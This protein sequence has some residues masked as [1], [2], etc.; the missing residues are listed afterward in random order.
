MVSLIP[1]ICGYFLDILI[2]DPRQLPHPVRAIGLLISNT[3]KVLRKKDRFLK[4]KGL[5]L[6]IF[7]SFLSFIIPYI[8][9]KFLN[10]INVL[11]GVIISSLL[12]FQIL[13]TKSLY[14]ETIKVYKAL[15]CGNIQLAKKEL[16]YLVSRDCETM[17]EEDIIRSTIETISENIVDGITSP[18]FY[19][20]L[21]GAP[22]GMFYK[23]VN[24]LDSMVGYKNE[25]YMDFGYFSAKFDDVINF[26]PARLTSYLIVF[27]SFVLRLNYKD[28]YTI[29]K[30]DKANHSS[31]NSGYA[32][33]PVAG[34]LGI[35]LGGKVSY[36]GVIHNKPTM[37]NED[38]RP[39]IEDI[40]STHKIMFLTSVLTL[41]LLII[42]Q[43]G[44]SFVR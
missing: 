39:N 21:G 35:R 22:L 10:S 27:S 19:I 25:K 13:A 30:R 14:T 5:V 6:L 2:G 8:L 34:A 41:I 37:G 38:R 11:V 23:A 17:E 28:S 15:N 24:T 12:I 9:L 42:I 3:E 4:F 26:I 40:K 20:M 32:E 7:V 36:F 16:S 29:L 1:L 18:L 33:A 31:P 44:V 43:L